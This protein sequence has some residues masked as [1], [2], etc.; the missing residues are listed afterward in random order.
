M[1]GL[2]FVGLKPQTVQ[3]YRRALQGF[4]NYLLDTDEQ[5]KSQA[6]TVRWIDS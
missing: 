1:A 6:P 2:Q 4:F 3:A 5:I